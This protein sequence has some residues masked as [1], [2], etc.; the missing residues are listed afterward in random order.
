MGYEIWIAFY[1]AI[2]ATFAVGLEVRR[3]VESG[4]RLAISIIAEGQTFGPMQSARDDKTYICITVMNKGDAPTTIT[5][6]AGYYYK[7]LWKWL[8]RKPDR[9]F[10]VPKPNLVP[11]Q[12]IPFFLEQGKIFY[13]FIEHTEESQRLM[14]DGYL[15]AAILGTH[16]TR[17]HFARV[18][19]QQVPK[20]ETGNLS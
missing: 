13:G 8:R 5:H 11:G 14:N 1:A 20:E 4:A 10:I 2:V 6:V 12:E 3:W 18:K 16:R 17:P 15:Y 9:I 7:N 19:K